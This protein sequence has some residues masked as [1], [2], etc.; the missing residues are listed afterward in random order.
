MRRMGAR[1][2]KPDGVLGT[3]PRLSGLM[4]EAFIF[5]PKKGLDPKEPP[6]PSPP[7]KPSARPACRGHAQSK[8]VQTSLIQF[9]KSTRLTI[10]LGQLA[11]PPALHH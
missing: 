8:G 6:V 5:G 1:T 4:V 3:L 11:I 2:Q 9:P 7:L 10:Y